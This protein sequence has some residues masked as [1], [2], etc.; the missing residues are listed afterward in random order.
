[1]VIQIEAAI[2]TDLP[3]I[4]E[5]L[6]DL[7]LDMEDLHYTQFLV[8]KDKGEMIAAGRIRLHEDGLPELCSLGVHPEYRSRGIGKGIVCGLLEKYP[9]S[10]VWLLSEIP[11]FFEKTGFVKTD[12]LPE[13][14]EDKSRRCRE[15]YACSNP[16]VM[17]FQA[18]NE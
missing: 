9:Q 15:L 8:V 4:M 16:V 1:M 17:Y 2:N 18:G 6:E 7:N 11:D 10:K 13:I 12:E 5:L 3:D 14:L